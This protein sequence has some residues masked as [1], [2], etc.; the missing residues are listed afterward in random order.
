MFVYSSGIVIVTY[1]IIIAARFLRVGGPMHFFSITLFRSVILVL[2]V[3]INRVKSVEVISDLI[4]NLKILFL[5]CRI[6]ND[7]EGLE[8]EKTQK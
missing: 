1:F 7:C 5:C 4:I 3:H 6:L 8:K 2:I